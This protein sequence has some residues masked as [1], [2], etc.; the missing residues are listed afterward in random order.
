ML[1]KSPASV[2]EILE[3]EAKKFT[4]ELWGIIKPHFRGLSTLA[5]AYDLSSDLNERDWQEA[6]D[7]NITTLIEAA[8][9][10]RL[11]LLASGYDHAHTW[12]EADEKFDEA[13]MEIHGAN[14]AR[15]NL[16]V[17]FTVFPGTKEMVEGSNKME[18]YSATHATVK[19]RSAAWETYD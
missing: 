9:R 19:V 8:L 12:P 13:E 2:T 15:Q 17:L 14:R 5:N 1:A 3:Q 16:Q 11:E 6:F 7:D 18:T 4:K 10:Y